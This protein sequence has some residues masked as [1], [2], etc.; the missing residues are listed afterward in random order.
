MH[1]RPAA[2][3]VPS[4]GFDFQR[5]AHLRLVE[6]AGPS[7]YLPYKSRDGVYSYLGYYFRLSKSEVKQLLRSMRNRG[8]IRIG[9]RG[10]RLAPP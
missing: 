8:L 3:S 7:L 4:G 2:A 5:I 9:N 10:I 6:K 1:L